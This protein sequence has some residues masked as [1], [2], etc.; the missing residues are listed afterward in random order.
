[1]E[2]L[3][4][5]IDE[6]NPSEFRTAY[7]SETLSIDWSLCDQRTLMRHVVPLT[8]WLGFKHDDVPLAQS[9]S[10]YPGYSGWKVEKIWIGELREAH[11]G[12]ALSPA[13]TIAKHTASFLQAWLYYGLLE[14]VLGK[15][16]KISYMMRP[17]END[18]E[19]LY[20]RNLH[21]CLRQIVHKWRLADE[22]TKRDMNS[23]ITKE[24]RLVETWI[25]RL[26]AW[27]QESIRTRRDIQYPGFVDLVAQVLPAIVRLAEGIIETAIYAYKGMFV[28]NISGEATKNARGAMV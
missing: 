6:N 27:S 1:M 3:F 19:L 26:A 22:A 15:K 9:L 23:H 8:P 20:S 17:N 16:I 28:E 4:F 7:H 5:Q 11:E 18:E 2:H 24:L 21:F 14:S 10:Q 13:A 25:S 12:L